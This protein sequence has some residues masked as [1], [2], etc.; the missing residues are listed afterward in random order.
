MQVLFTLLKALRAGGTNETLQVCVNEGVSVSVRVTCMGSPLLFSFPNVFHDILLIYAMKRCIHLLVCLSTHHQ[1]IL[2]IGDSWHCS[3]VWSSYRPFHKVQ[4][5]FFSTEVRVNHLIS[6]ISVD[7]TVVWRVSKYVI[8]IM[9]Q[10]LNKNIRN[11]IWKRT[12]FKMDL[13]NLYRIREEEWQFNIQFISPTK[14]CFFI[15]FVTLYAVI[16]YWNLFVGDVEKCLSF[17]IF[18]FSNFPTLFA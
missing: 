8:G 14:P 10:T 17:H 5:R 3:E 15:T 7:V 12:L 13:I 18:L 16:F 2:C 11:N 1:L 4:R 6:V 9:L